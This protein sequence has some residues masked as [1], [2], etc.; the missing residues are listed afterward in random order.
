LDDKPVALLVFDLVGMNEEVVSLIRQQAERQHGIPSSKVAIT[1]THTHSGPAGFTRYPDI[2]QD[3][4]EFVHQTIARAMDGLGEAR[5]TLSNAYMGYGETQ[6]SRVCTDRNTPDQKIDTTVA[7][8][9]V[10]G[11][12][13]DRDQPIAI[14]G[15]FPCHPTV[16]GADNLLFSGDLFGEAC[17]AIED[18]YNGRTVCALTNGAEGDISTRYVRQS[19]TFE[20]SA[21]LGGKLAEK[22]LEVLTSVRTYNDVAHLGILTRRFP[23]PLKYLPDLVEARSQLAASKKKL[24]RLKDEGGSHGDIR[25]VET[26]IQGAESL[27]ESVIAS[28]KR[29]T[30]RSVIV[31]MMGIRLGDII[32]ITIPGE[33]FNQL[34]VEIK[35]SAHPAVK[36]IVLGLANGYVGYFPTREAQDKRSYEVLT[37]QFDFRASELLTD[38][39][40]TL[41]QML[42]NVES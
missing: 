22:L 13:G 33:P 11:R 17:K 2:D 21:R 18:F 40:V 42:Q 5:S 20:E 25:V 3:A 30:K 16:L 19:Q 4:E 32:L 26:E 24:Q 31:E 37:S 9:K 35:A 8:V 28:K 34:G 1:C 6:L 36:V 38:E 10:V 14:L 29:G 23:I 41:V 15:N 7:V 39:A 12:D 27:L